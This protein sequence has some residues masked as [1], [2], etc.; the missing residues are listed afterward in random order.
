MF[1]SEEEITWQCR[2]CGYP[3]KG[4][5]VTCGLSGQFWC[6]PKGTFPEAY[7]API[8]PISSI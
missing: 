6:T 7:D 2:K 5:G 1:V 8:A 4:L 3:M